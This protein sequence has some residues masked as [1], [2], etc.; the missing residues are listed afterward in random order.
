MSLW[1]IQPNL[2]DF[3]AAQK[4]TIGEVLDIRFEA[5]D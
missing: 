3:N 4:N 1:H 5:V 2:D